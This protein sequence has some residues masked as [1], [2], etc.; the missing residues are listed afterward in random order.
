MRQDFAGI[1]SEGVEGM[2]AHQRADGAIVYD[3]AAP[4]VYP[5]QAIMPLAF[6]YA[7]LGT[8]AEHKGSPLLLE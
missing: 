3:P 8:N 4:I 1:V 7:G 2:L 6:C 5:Q